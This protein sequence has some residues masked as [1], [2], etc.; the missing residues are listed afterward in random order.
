MFKCQFYFILTEK[1]SKIKMGIP[2]ILW[3]YFVFQSV[4]Y[5]G[6][7]RYYEQDLEFTLKKEKER[8]KRKCQTQLL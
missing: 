8:K 5:R 1:H 7:G 2:H 3:S 6:L 4:E